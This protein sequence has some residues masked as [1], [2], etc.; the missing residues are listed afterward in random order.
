[1]TLVKVSHVLRHLIARLHTIE[2]VVGLQPEKP[3]TTDKIG[4]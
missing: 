1:M 4:I 3:K 2:R